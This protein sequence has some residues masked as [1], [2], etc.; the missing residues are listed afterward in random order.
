MPDAFLAA[1]RDAWLE[2]LSENQSLVRIEA[3]NRP[4]LGN[5]LEF[6]ELKRLFER[7]DD[8]AQHAVR[9]FVE[10]W[11]QRRDARPMFAAFADEVQAELD[12]DDWPHA[13]RDRLGLGHYSGTGDAPLPIAL[14]LYSLADVYAAQTRQAI[15]NAVALPTVFDGEMHEFFFPVPREHPY[16]AT[17]HLVPELADTLT[18]EVVHCRI[19]YERGHIYRLG[20]IMRPTQLDDEQLRE[21]RDLHLYALREACGRDDFGEALEGRT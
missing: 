10:S 3:L 18:T 6:D 14:M 11:N 7:T 5:A 4:L 1:N 8:D 19:D 2:R 16:G 12:D 9:S 20:E 21:A 13:L 15:A 17:V